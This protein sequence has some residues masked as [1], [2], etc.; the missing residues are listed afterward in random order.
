MKIMRI[1]IAAVL[2]CASWTVPAADSPVGVWRTVDDRSGKEKS[3]VRIVEVNGELRGTVE[4]LF[5]DTGED[6]NPVCEKCAGD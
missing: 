3:L 4:R 5:R 2:A 1:I 6:P